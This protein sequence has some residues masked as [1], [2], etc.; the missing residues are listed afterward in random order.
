MAIKTVPY[1]ENTETATTRRVATDY[2][3][4]FFEFSLMNLSGKMILENSGNLDTVHQTVNGK[5]PTLPFG[6]YILRMQS[7]EKI[8][9]LKIIKE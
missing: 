8:G 7:G 2:C 1:K 6:V 5:L 9:V 3:K 4:D